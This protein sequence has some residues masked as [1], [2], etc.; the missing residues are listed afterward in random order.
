MREISVGSGV[1]A[2]IHSTWPAVAG[3]A[4][5]M[6][7]SRSITTQPGADDLN[8]LTLIAAAT[9]QRTAV[10]S[11]GMHAQTGLTDRQTKIARRK[12]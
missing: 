11:I 6:L 3:L 7:A 5:P 12:L 4:L 2:R 10:A 8:D 1:V 9:S